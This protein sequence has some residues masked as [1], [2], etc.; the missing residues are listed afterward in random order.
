MAGPRTEP[1]EIGAMADR[2]PSAVAWH[3]L[4]GG[5]DLTFA[6]WHTGSNQLARGFAER[7]LGHGDRVIIAIDPDEPFPWLVAYAAVHRAGAVAVP[8]NT[9]L[10]AP[11]LRAIVAHAEPTGV[12]A[13]SGV[14]GGLLRT[15]SGGATPHPRWVATIGGAEGTLDWLELFHPDGSDLDPGP[16]SDRSTEIM[17]IM[18]TSGTTG[19]PKAV[20]VRYGA[21]RDG[22]TPDWSGLGFMTASPFST[23]SGALLVYGPMSGGLS[24]WYLPRF[25][26]GE[27]LDVTED[28]RPVA[29]FIVPAM[30]QLIVAH[31]RFATADLS[32]LAAL[33]IGGAPVARATLQR[34]GERLPRADI[35]VGYGLT[36]FGAVARS[37]SGDNGRH[38]GSAGRPLPDVEVRIVD[39]HGVEVPTGGSGEITVRGAGPSREYYKEA[40][41]TQQT[42]QNGWLFS[43]DLGYVD[44]DG[45]LWITGRTKDLIIRGGHNITPGEVEEVLFSH[46][47]VVDAVVA[48]IPHD[49]LGEDVGA[50]VV[51]HKGSDATAADLRG[52]L[53]ERLADYKVPRSLHL[54]PSL[55]R[56]AAGKVL[57][58]ELPASPDGTPRPGRGP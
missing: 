39:G 24:G 42:W 4:A 58:H 7:G 10:A 46:P 16:R 1:D 49:V 20:V 21:P 34:L 56:N 41:T 57:R 12:L 23:T 36:E 22:R 32:G 53:L 47:D 28:R 45:F 15:S 29:S 35:L 27:W 2:H 33:T 54:V 52:F 6:A 17:D 11:E 40:T 14:V 44:G 26:A 3:N 50:W 5:A 48:G 18:Y 38:L 19:A 25:D 37:P 51:L 55:P 43:G 30:A 31:P 9:R 8:V 13:S